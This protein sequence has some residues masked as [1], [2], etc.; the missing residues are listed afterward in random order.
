MHDVCFANYKEIT[1][2]LKYQ[3]SSSADEVIEIVKHSYENKNGDPDSS[4]FVGEKG[5]YRDRETWIEGDILVKDLVRVSMYPE[6]PWAK[7]LTNSTRAPA[8]AND[9]SFRNG[10]ERLQS[11]ES[12]QYADHYAKVHGIYEALREGSFPNE[13]RYVTILQWQLVEPFVQ[14]GNHRL[15]ALAK[16]NLDNVIKCYVGYNAQDSLLPSSV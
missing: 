15:L 3:K 7:Y 12:S 10:L 4:H 14:D 9:K 16:H 13:L 8:Q 2:H 5:R 1:K 11:L 6:A